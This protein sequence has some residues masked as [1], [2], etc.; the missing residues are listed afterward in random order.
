TDNRPGR[1]QVAEGGTLFLDEIGDLPM[2]LQPRL[3]RFLQDHEYERVGDPHTRTAD[4]RVIAATHHDLARAVA[5]GKFREDLYYRLNVFSLSLPALRERADDIRPIAQALI[6]RLAR[7]YARPARGLSPEAERLLERHPWPGNLR[8]LRSVIEH[9]VIVCDGE[10]LQ[11]EHLPF[12]TE[13]PA[14]QE[15][16]RA[17][18]PVSLDELERAHIEAV[19]ALSPSLEAA[20]RSL[21]IDSS[22]LYRKRKQYKSR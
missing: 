17:G 3:L 9:A 6:L 1:I 2:S 22:T 4:V 7:R 20:A 8:E 18:D 19:V 13:V 16:L 10:L 15:H 12:G 21:K 14:Q 11:P 5:A